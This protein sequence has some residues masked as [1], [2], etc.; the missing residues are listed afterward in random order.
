MKNYSI[1][2]S[3]RIRSTPYTSRIEKQGVTSYTTYN[4]MLLPAAFGSIED[5][6]HH[7][8]KHVQVWDVAAERQVEI[9]GKDSARLI[10]LM[11]CRDLSKSKVGR[12]YYCPIIDDQA[13]IINDPV[14]LKLNEEKW[15][16]SVAD[17][18]VI[19]FA[20][21][22]A[23]GNNFDVKIIE[24]N[25]DIMAVQ[26]PKSFKLME[27]VFGEKITKLKFF[28]FDYFEFKGTKHLIAQSGWSK[29]GGYEIYVENTKSGLELYDYL[30][31]AGKE[32]N[33]K[34]GCPNLIERIESA[35]LSYG[36]DMDNGDNP[37]ECGFDKFINLD[38]NIIFLGKE[39]LK[40]IKSEGIKKKLMG[41]I[42]EA[43]EISLSRSL[44]IKDEKSNKVGELR[45]A[46]YSPHFEKVIGIAMLDMS[47]LR[48]SK[49]VKIDIK[50]STYNGK[51]CDLPFI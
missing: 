41:V 6:Y 33:I 28:G 43:K 16:I 32:F 51:V 2:K 36:N 10:Q 15:W 37:Y 34:P 4:H 45:S 9:S 20:K 30:F 21:G 42:L 22:L 40:Q 23:I 48:M 46:C 3:R 44:D 12:C 18:D 47:F 49:S 8:K 29:Q 31:E 17:S 25:V 26:G 19:L 39:K 13:G 7:L 27:K 1:G 50:N 35:L 14:V 24:P 11:T 38:S 5:S